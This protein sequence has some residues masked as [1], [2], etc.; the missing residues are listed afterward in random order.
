MR[1]E[2]KGKTVGS[3]STHQDPQHADQMLQIS[4]SKQLSYQQAKHWTMRWLI[5]DNLCLCCFLTSSS[6]LCICVSVCLHLFF[7]TKIRHRLQHESGRPVFGFVTGDLAAGVTAPFH[8][9]SSPSLTVLPI[10]PLSVAMAPAWSPQGPSYLHSS[11]GS[12]EVSIISSPA[13]CQRK[14]GVRLLAVK[15]FKS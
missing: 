6:C 12:T 4:Q 14:A 13:W 2:Q 7:F 5:I 11:F 10:F 1:Q 15:H 3:R 9:T 8:R